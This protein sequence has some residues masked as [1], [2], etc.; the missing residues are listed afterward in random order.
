MTNCK[1]LLVDS[2]P[3]FLVVMGINLVKKGCRVTVASNGETAVKALNDKKFDLVISNM[4]TPP[5]DNFTILEK[6]KKFNPLTKVILMS[7][8]PEA[9]SSVDTCYLPQHADDYLFKSDVMNWVF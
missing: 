3:I 7:E 4:E 5:L 2:N 9:S 6:A 8:S 1:V